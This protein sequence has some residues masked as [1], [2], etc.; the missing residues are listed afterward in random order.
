[1]A[2]RP[3]TSAVTRR[4]RPKRAAVS[5]VV[6]GP[7]VRAYRPSS[8]PSGSATDWVNA[9]GTPTG[10]ATPTP[11]RS[12]PMSSTATHQAWPP[13]ETV[14]ARLAA[15]SPSSQPPTSFVVQRSQL[16]TAEQ[17]RQQH[18]VQRQCGSA[19]LGPR[20]VALVHECADVAE[21]QRRRERRRGCGLHL[22]HPQ[23]ALR[24]PVH[25]LGERGHVID[26]L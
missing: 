7:C 21:Q 26:V 18:A 4:P 13:N 15:C 23:P 2:S 19:P 6:N 17:L 14:S 5:C 11:S 20:A 9:A 8:S 22:D 10:T 3:S 25:H 16:D 24:Y 12:R 1:M